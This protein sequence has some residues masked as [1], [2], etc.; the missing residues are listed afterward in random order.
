MKMRIS[1]RVGPLAIWRARRKAAKNQNSKALKATISETPAVPN[2]ATR[3]RSATGK[4]EY[5]ICRS[6]VNIQSRPTPLGSRAASAW[7]T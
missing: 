4:I 3:K 6:I 1:Q 2:R 5:C 7:L